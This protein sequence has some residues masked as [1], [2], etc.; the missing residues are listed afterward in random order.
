MRRLLS[1]AIVLSAAGGFLF[2]RSGA[3]SPQSSLQE[4]KKIIDLKSDLSGPIAPGDSVI[5]LVGNFAAQHNGAVITCDSAVRYSDKRIEFFGNVLINK[6]TTYIYGERAEYNGELNEARVYSD[7]IK[8]V[9]GDATLYTYKFVFNT[10]TNIGVFDQGGVM[11]N[12]DNLLEA[13]RGYYYA[14]TKEMVGVDDVQMRNE[15][16]EL[17]GDSVIY[18]MATDHAFFFERTNIWSQEGDYLYADRGSYN[19]ADSLY[20]VTRNGYVLTEKQEMWSD[21]IDYFRA[22]EHVILRRDIQIDDTEHKVLAFGEYGEYWKEPGNAFLTQR[23]SMVS[24]DSSQGDSLFMRADS[25]FLFTR[26]IGDDAPASVS[27][28]STVLSRSDSLAGRGTP[29]AADSAA[30]GAAV[31]RSGVDSLGGGAVQPDS[32]GGAPVLPD[33]LGGGVGVADSL[34]KAAADTVKLTKE[35]IKEAA[36]KVKAA[37]KAEAA[38]AKKKKLAEIAAVRKEKAMAKLLVLTQR[39]EVRLAARKLKEESK[40]KAR[41]ARAARKRKPIHVDLEALRRIDSL[42]AVNASQQDSLMNLLA[43]SLFT[44]PVV[45]L[46]DSLDSLD[47]LSLPLDS[48]YRLVRGYRNVK[49]YRTDFQTVCDSMVAISTDSTIHLYIDPVLWNQNNQINSEVMDIFTLNQQIVRAEFVGSP[50]MVSELDTTHYNQVAG[51]TMTAYFRQNNIYR[52]DVNGNARTIYYIQDGEPPEVTGMMV[53]ESG[54]ISFFIEERQ[55]VQI[56]Y[57]GNPVYSIYPLDKIP[58]TQ[59][60]YL[61]GFKWQGARRPTQ[62]EVFDRRIRPSERERRSAMP[63]PD[64]PILGRVD[65]HKKRLMELRQWFDRNDQVDEATVQWMRELGF[66]VGQPRE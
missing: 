64:F 45:T 40:I 18:N 9:D 7:I 33:S 8:V 36:R 47:S 57:R 51:K 65:S 19:K 26:R 27:S 56:T 4:Q 21:T 58:P 61:K 43:D 48:I 1:I 12:R 49:M 37:K 17:T 62:A 22:Q 11:I 53:I 20:K 59:D 24:Y 2:A 38:K 29:I 3:Q 5:F 63:H 32:L 23:P 52:N 31:G 30:R 10:K 14:D 44:P 16:Y 28:D 35:Q 50:M 46:V 34:A 54:D 6:N 25:M 55:V 42:I 66:E 60:L 13:I 39:E 41:R 15:E